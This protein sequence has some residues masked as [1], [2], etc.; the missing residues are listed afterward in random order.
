MVMNDF[1]KERYTRRDLTKE[2][3]NKYVCLSE[4]EDIASITCSGVIL[5][6]TDT[7]DEKDEETHRI[8][9]EFGTDFFWI[10]T[11]NTDE[12]RCFCHDIALND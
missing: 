3:P 8:R 2:Y 5:S 10:S 9:Q 7:L 1:G 11:A 6:I 12:S 4:L